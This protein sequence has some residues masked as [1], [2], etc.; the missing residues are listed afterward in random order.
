MRVS[1][2]N[3]HPAEGQSPSQD[4]KAEKKKLGKGHYNSCLLLEPGT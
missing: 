3:N 1:P 4:P 2:P